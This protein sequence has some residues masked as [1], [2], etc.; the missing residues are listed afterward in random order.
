M[1][2]DGASTTATETARPMVSRGLDGERQLLRTGLRQG[3]GRHPQEGLVSD[4]LGARF[5]TRWTPERAPSFYGGIS[6]TK[7]RS[8]VAHARRR[9]FLK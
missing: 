5:E 1:D 9:G 4:W 7:M 6:E 3:A 2:N 8:M